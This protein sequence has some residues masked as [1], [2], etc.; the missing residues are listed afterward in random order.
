MKL[1]YT[2][3]YAFVIALSSFFWS[4]GTGMNDPI[5]IGDGGGPITHSLDTAVGYCFQMGKNGL[6]EQ[7]EVEIHGNKI[8]GQGVRVYTNEQKVFRLIIEGV[9]DGEEADVNIYATGGNKRAV[10]SYEH[11]EIWVLAEEELMVKNRKIKLAEGDFKFYRTTCRA[12]KNVDTTRYD[13]FAGFINGY[14]VVSKKG[15]YGVINKKNELIIPTKYRDLG[16]VNEGSIS[17]FDEH[18]GLYGLLNID[19]EIIIEAKY[20]EVHC[21]NEGLAAF[22]SEE[23]KWGFMNKDL[24]III[25]PIYMGINFFKP[26][27]SRHAFYEGLANVQTEN[28][29]WNYINTKGETVIAGDFLFAKSFVNGEAEVFK[30]NKWYTINKSGK[31]IKNCD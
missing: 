11:R 21:F 17:F 28:S 27:P 9:I 15:Y 23:G 24:E 1:S 25:E 31:C 5:A 10:E 14:A 7:I 26:D 6:E 3:I 19:G 13:T 8:E 2:V 22:L 4:C 16:V 29:K 18:S 30:D 20:V 12:Y